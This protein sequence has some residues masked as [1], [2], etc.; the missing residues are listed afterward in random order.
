MKPARI[1]SAQAIDDHNL[2]IKFTNNEL[3]KYD[4]SKLLDNPMFSPLKNPAFFRNFIID[5][6]GYALVWNED[7]DISEYEL[8]QNGISITKE[9]NREQG[10]DKIQ[11]HKFS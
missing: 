10:T 7:I 8:W 2:I 1:V 5:S 3:K 9:G 6:G 11:F 4:I